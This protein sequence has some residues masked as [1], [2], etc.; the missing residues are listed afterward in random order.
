[1]FIVSLIYIK[2]LEFIDKLRSKHLEFLDK[3]YAK[4]IF[5]VSGPKNPRTG[6]IIVANK[7]TKAQLEL[8]LQED[9]FFTDG[10]AEYEITEFIPSKHNPILDSYF[11]D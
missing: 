1:M 2:P 7:V 10:A 5:L 3:Y 6:G 11:H 4:N 9:P 8:I